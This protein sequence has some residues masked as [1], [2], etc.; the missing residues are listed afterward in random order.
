[1]F[2]VELPPGAES[3]EH[4]HSVDLAEDVYAVVQ[5]AGTVF[6]DGEAVPLGP[7]RFVAVTPESTR[8]V[9]AGGEGLVY[10]AICA[11]E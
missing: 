3:V 2:Q 7:G 4:D 6:V 9:R 11:A 1:V 10:I 5:G 8:R